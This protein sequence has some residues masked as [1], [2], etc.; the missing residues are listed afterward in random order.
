MIDLVAGGNFASILG[1]NNKEIWNAIQRVKKSTGKYC[2]YA[3]HRQ[4]RWRDAYIEMLKNRT[5]FTSVALFSTGAEATEAFWRVARTYT[6]KPGIWGGLVDPDEVGESNPAYDSMHGVTLGAKIMGG[7]FHGPELAY[8]LPIAEKRLH[9]E[10]G[11]SAGMIMEPY[12]SPSAQFHKIEP[13]INRIVTN[14]KTFKDM[15]LCV[16]EV[17]GG[18][19]RTGLLWAHEHYKKKGRFMLS[20]DFIAIGCGGGLPLSALLGPA[21]I[22]ESDI[23]KENGYLHSTHSGNPLMCAVGCAVIEQMDKLKLIEISAY[24]GSLMHDML[25]EF[26][27]PTHGKGLLAGLEFKDNAEVKE[28]TARCLTRGVQVCDTGRKWVKLGP[29]LN[30]NF[31]ELVAGITILKEITEEVINERHI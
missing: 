7:N 1:D 3:P 13:T 9:T 23:V 6:G 21:D 18:F 16:D 26:P 17:Q 28:V 20:P 29:A 30:I 12:H 11:A 5:G 14:L 24:N 19:G 25:K 4:D 10:G 8:W 2:S 31:S 27:I 22:M 15:L